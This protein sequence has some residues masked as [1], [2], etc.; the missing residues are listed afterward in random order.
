MVALREERHDVE[1]IGGVEFVRPGC[2][3][4]GL[5]RL[6]SAGESGENI[7]DDALDVSR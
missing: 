6:E 5:G 4:R 1:A 2:R 3:R 7:A